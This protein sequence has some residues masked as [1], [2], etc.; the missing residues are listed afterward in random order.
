MIAN[1][2]EAHSCPVSDSSSALTRRCKTLL[3]FKTETVGDG[4]SKPAAVAAAAVAKDRK[5]VRCTVLVAGT[6]GDDFSVDISVIIV[7][8]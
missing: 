5:V 3:S 8:P 2:L 4:A 1:L 6:S 7:E